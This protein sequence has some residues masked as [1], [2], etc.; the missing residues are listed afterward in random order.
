MIERRRKRDR[1]SNEQ[2]EKRYLTNI[3]KLSFRG[4]LVSSWIFSS[5]FQQQDST[6]PE[7]CRNFF[8]DVSQLYIMEILWRYVC[9]GDGLK[10][11]SLQMT[12]RPVGREILWKLMHNIATTSAYMT[13]SM[14]TP[15][16]QRC[17]ICIHMRA[18]KR[19]Q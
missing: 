14:T 17:V 7:H 3:Y 5:I 16:R 12:Q 9:R 8:G 6:F 1:L 19:S 10:C 4:L 15:R 11:Q 13:A 18:M 2:E